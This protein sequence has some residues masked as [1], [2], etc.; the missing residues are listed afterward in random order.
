MASRAPWPE[1]EIAVLDRH[2]D[3][4]DW[5]QRVSAAIQ[6]RTTKALKVR[7]AKRRSELGLADGRRVDGG[8]GDDDDQERANADAVVASQELL[9]AIQRAGVRP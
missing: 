3:Q 7:M 1:E 2:I 9:A 4:P 6:G 5:L 8:C